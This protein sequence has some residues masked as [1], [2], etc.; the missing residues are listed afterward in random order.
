[1]VS[2]WWISVTLPSART[3]LRWL[4]LSRWYLLLQSG[5]L[6]ASAFKSLLH[7]EGGLC[8]CVLDMLERRHSYAC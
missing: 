5:P 6:P 7:G 8:V 3:D 4:E 1:M 2:G